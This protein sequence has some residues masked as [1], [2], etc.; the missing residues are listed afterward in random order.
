MNEQERVAYLRSMGYQVYYPRYVLPG[1]KPSP[2]YELPTESEF[3]NESGAGT[4]AAQ[5]KTSLSAGKKQQARP[6]N[7]GLE[8]VRGQLAEEPKQSR[9]DN[10][11]TSRRLQ[12]AKANVVEPLE[13]QRYQEPS[14][15]QSN[16][17]SAAELRFSLQFYPVNSSIAIINESPHQVRGKQNKEVQDLLRAILTALGVNIPDV[18]FQAEQFNWPLAEGLDVLGDPRRAASL[19]LHGFVSQRL[20]QD[21]FQNLLV[22]TSQLPDLLAPNPAKHEDP[23]GDF[24]AVDA[25]YHLTLSHSLPAMLAHPQLKRE[26]WSHLQVLRNRLSNA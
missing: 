6:R 9:S 18:G 19:A 16:S 15:A 2:H 4:P 26:V 8:K 10:E 25:G 12:D 3:G 21:R 14:A 22:F 5:E 1:A 23:F 17:E 7:R 20:E 13:S 11:P 24:G